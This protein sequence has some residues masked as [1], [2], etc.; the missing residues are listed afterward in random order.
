MLLLTLAPFRVPWFPTCCARFNI[1]PEVVAAFAYRAWRELAPAAYVPTA[2]TFMLR[3]LW[4]LTALQVVAT[5]AIAAC[6]GACV[7][8]WTRC[9][10]VSAGTAPATAPAVPSAVSPSVVFSAVVAMGLFLANVRVVSRAFS[11]PTLRENFALPFLWL[12]IAA[13]LLLVRRLDATPSRPL[14]PDASTSQP[15]T[16]ASSS[17]GADTPTKSPSVSTARRNNDTAASNDSTAASPKPTGATVTSSPSVSTPSAASATA[18][19]VSHTSSSSSSSLRPSLLHVAVVFFAAAFMTSWQFGAFALLLQLA[20]LHACALIGVL[21][22]ST[23]L[24]VAVCLLVSVALTAVV[25]MGNAMLLTSLL[26]VGC[27]ATAVAYGT[28]AW[29][30]TCTRSGPSSTT[31]ATSTLCSRVSFAVT[32]L[33]GMVA[34]KI[35]LSWALGLKDDDHVF[36]ILR[37][38]LQDYK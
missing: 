23:V 27:I 14:S 12:E 32:T 38:K 6:L 35:A 10:S 16:K 17:S 26:T 29:L 24:V 7:V 25:M 37:A 33:V 9:R 28:V 15:T 11:N 13:V 31:T 3:T 2:M 19:S 5:G 36:R 30:S 4:A 21:A 34:A 1:A 8:S 20:S 22:P 18:G